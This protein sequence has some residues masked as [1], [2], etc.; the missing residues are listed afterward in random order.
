MGQG[1]SLLVPLSQF[2]SDPPRAVG[3][4]Q[5]SPALQRWVASNISS[6]P[7]GTTPLLATAASTTAKTPPPYG[8]PPIAAPSPRCDH[9][10]SCN[11]PLARGG[12]TRVFVT[13]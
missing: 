1:T 9:L 13:G 4:T 5:V 6:S 11:R 2:F 3:A 7:V 10:L 12:A 8:E